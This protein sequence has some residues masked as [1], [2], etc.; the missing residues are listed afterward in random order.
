MMPS[1]EQLN[2]LSSRIAL[3]AVASLTIIALFAFSRISGSG[4]LVALAGLS[5]LALALFT[6]WVCA[7][8]K[9]TPYGVM[10]IRLVVACLLLSVFAAL[11]VEVGTLLGTHPTYFEVAPL[12]SFVKNGV[13]RI[14]LNGCI[15][16]GC[17]L[18]FLCRSKHTVLGLCRRLIHRL[19]AWIGLKRLIGLCCIMVLCCVFAVV[20]RKAFGLSF[21]VSFC[22]CAAICVS[23]AYVFRCVAK[24]K[25]SASG[26]FL[27]L[28]LPWA[29]FFACCAPAISG[30]SWDDQIHYANVQDL[31]YVVNAPAPSVEASLYNPLL[32]VPALNNPHPLD[33]GYVL[34]SEMGTLEANIDYLYPSSELLYVREGVGSALGLYNSVGYIP[35]AA[36]LWLGR[37]LHLPVLWVYTMGRC[38]NALFYVLAT[39]AAIRIIPCKKVLLCV[40]GLLPG[41][42]F[43]AAN[44][45]YDS[46]VICMMYLLSSLVVRSITSKDGSVGIGQCAAMLAVGLLSIG[47]KAIY[48]L[49]L[50]IMLF[51][52]SRKFASRD[53]SCVFRFGVVAVTVIAAS[54]FA[55]PFVISGGEAYTDTRINQGVDPMGQLVW[56]LQDPLSSASVLLGFVFGSYISP[57]TFEGLSYSFAYMGDFAFAPSCL[58]LLL[59]V[60]AACTD[61]DRVSNRLSKTCYG[62]CTVG[63][64]LASI[65]LIV[66]SLYLSFTPVGHNTVDG[67]QPRYLTPLVFPL[68][69]FALNPRVINVSTRWKG[70]IGLAVLMALPFI[71]SCASSV[72]LF[73]RAW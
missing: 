59:V 53:A 30:L 12:S 56:I 20:S 15:V 19:S 42:L 62:V 66:I 1:T 25:A 14:I 60:V 68:L 44:Y 37:L 21:R 27:A 73:T 18:L 48:F 46:W 57:G 3:V 34:T 45:S 24:K 31:S 32:D 55:L 52:P 70:S 39:Y 6:I 51:I 64:V 54:S 41:A 38:A 69:L 65:L 61:S 43:L 16:Y 49:M 63:V 72:W 36:A 71:A 11:L 40:V 47:P 29:L 26:L 4:S 67:V 10:G 13:F 5:V 7:R 9:S 23:A 17:T 2:R 22:F 35:S 58:S 8:E 28:S 33:R 50:L